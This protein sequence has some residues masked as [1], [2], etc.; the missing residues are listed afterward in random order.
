MGHAGLRHT[1]TFKER[2]KMK[3]TGYGRIIG[4]A[5]EV[6]WSNGVVE[7]ITT[8][9]ERSARGVDDYLTEIEERRGASDA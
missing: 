4:W 9:D 3:D 8:V 5:I 7:K 6:E 2:E 1:T